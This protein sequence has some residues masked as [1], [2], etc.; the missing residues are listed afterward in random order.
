MS[1]K[2]LP[3]LLL[4]WSLR[5]ILM[6][7]LK[8][9]YPLSINLGQ[10]FIFQKKKKK[11]TQKSPLDQYEDY[12][13]YSQTFIIIFLLCHWIV[14][15]LMNRTHCIVTGTVFY[16]LA[17]WQW[18]CKSSG[19]HTDTLKFS[20]YKDDFQRLSKRQRKFTSLSLFECLG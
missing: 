4:M 1:R 12:H 14:I 3:W 9:K 10:K 5:S 17:L 7:Y 13:I 18:L 2:C 19:P 15:Y 16:S 6:I 20:L 11:Q 8:L